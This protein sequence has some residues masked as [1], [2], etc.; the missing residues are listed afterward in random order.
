MS[1]LD[2]LIIS[3]YLSS[4]K[5]RRKSGK[6]K[7]HSFFNI[8][9]LENKTSYSLKRKKKRMMSFRAYFRGHKTFSKFQFLPSIIYMNLDISEDCF[10]VEIQ[11]NFICFVIA[12]ASQDVKMGMLN[13]THHSELL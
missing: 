12:E 8:K 4:M 1:I 3:T 2:N 13:L 11:I 6:S 5:W 9:L 7:S 10:C